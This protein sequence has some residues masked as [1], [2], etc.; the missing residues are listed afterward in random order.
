[1]ADKII[2]NI[3]FAA[4]D[5]ASIII[6]DHA[7]LI[8]GACNRKF[9]GLVDDIRMTDAEYNELNEK[10]KTAIVKFASGKAGVAVTGATSMLYAKD[11]QIFVSVLNSIVAQSIGEAMAKYDNPM[12]APIVA[13]DT[14][15]AGDSKSYEIDT[16]AL[17]IAQKGTYG[18]NITN[19][20]PFAKS[21]ITLTP[22]TYCEGVQLDFIRLIANGYDWGYAVARVYAGFIYAQ[23]AL[24]VGKVFNSTILNG[25]PLYQ[26]SFTLPAYT[27]LASDVG[28]LSGANEDDV[29]ALGTRPAFNGISATATSGGF[30]T[31]DEYIRGGYLKEI[32]NV[33]SVVLS[34]FTNYAAPFTTANASNLRAIPNG[35][36]VLVAKSRGPIVRLLREDYIRVVETPANE[37]TLN[38]MEY[39]YFQAFDA[40]V[41][42]GSAFGV[43]ATGV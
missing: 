33:N 13:I 3:M 11:N 12:L 16:K 24:A 5:D 26:S 39:S 6:S 29:I 31:K 28:M 43:Q 35:Y 23:Y 41:A 21:S 20:M 9:P 37:N 7:R 19:L 8:A 40:D 25:T 17:P 38:R 32:C 36:I 14:V 4:N 27:Q 30:Q 18:S 34:N 42:T 1:M 10:V 22:K 2:R 15:K